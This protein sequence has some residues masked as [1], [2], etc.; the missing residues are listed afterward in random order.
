MS[1]VPGMRVRALVR[2]HMFLARCVAADSQRKAVFA[3][4]TTL[5]ASLVWCR[6]VYAPRT[7]KIASDS[8][9]GGVVLGHNGYVVMART[10]ADDNS[11]LRCVNTGA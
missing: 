2:I 4:A 7:G 9:T 8:E 10:H 5:A 3:F 1:L 11:Y 6:T